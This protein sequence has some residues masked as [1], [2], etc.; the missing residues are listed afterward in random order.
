MIQQDF[1]Y[2]VKQCQYEA[3]RGLKTTTTKDF[4]E[5]ITRVKKSAGYGEGLFNTCTTVPPEG[6]GIKDSV[7][8]ETP[9]TPALNNYIALLTKAANN[10]NWVMSLV[11]MIPCIQVCHP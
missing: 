3:D 2:L 11:A 9:A 5:S 10:Q 1:L 4:K 7:V 8:L 6:L